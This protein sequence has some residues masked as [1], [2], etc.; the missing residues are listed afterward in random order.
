MRHLHSLT[1][2]AVIA[3]S[4][5]VSAGATTVG[6]PFFEVD[7]AAGG[8]PTGSI[9]DFFGAFG[10]SGIK[11]VDLSGTVTRA[12]GDPTAVGKTLGFSTNV[13]GPSI[14]AELTLGTTTL[15]GSNVFSASTGA[16]DFDPFQ[17]GPGDLNFRF[18]FLPPFSEVPPFD[19]FGTFVF[20]DDFSAFPSRDANVFDFPELEGM[21][22]VFLDGPLPTRLFEDPDDPAFNFEFIEGQLDIDRIT[23]GL[24]GG[25]PLPAIPLPA[26]LP[27]ILG[28]LGT[29]AALRTRR[30]R[31]M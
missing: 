29:L 19:P 4:S 10:P 16:F 28:A 30:R 17:D 12:V 23:F 6:Q 21:L 31:M 22:S 3:V 26:G 14:E 20:E 2:T 5:T 24:V 1:V 7:M 9:L 13:T 18:V 15:D 8:N 27:L 11:Q 25:D